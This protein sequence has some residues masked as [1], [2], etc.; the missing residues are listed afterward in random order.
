MFYFAL[1]FSRL[2]CLKITSPL[3]MVVKTQLF[4][5]DLLTFWFSLFGLFSVVATQKVNLL[6]TGPLG[7]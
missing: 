3:W 2:I 1:L 5:A 4:K 6:F 7:K